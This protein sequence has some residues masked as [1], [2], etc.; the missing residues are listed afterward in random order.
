MSY[1]ALSIKISLK[2]L[3]TSTYFAVA[4]SCA[5]LKPTQ[6]FTV[7]HEKFS[8]LKLYVFGIKANKKWSK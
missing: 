8:P 1:R 5:E 3:F 7:M 4:V 6:T 2:T